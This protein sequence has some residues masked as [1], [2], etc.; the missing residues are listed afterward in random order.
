MQ[1]FVYWNR[2]NRM[3]HLGQQTL[4]GHNSLNIDATS[5]IYTSIVM[6]WSYLSYRHML[7]MKKFL[8][9]TFWFFS[10][11]SSKQCKLNTPKTQTNINIYALSR[12]TSHTDT[13]TGRQSFYYLQL[14]V[15]PLF[16]SFLSWIHTYTH[17]YGHLYYCLMN[18]YCYQKY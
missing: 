17:R 7:W 3:L 14:C 8:H 11:T 10:P 2:Y 9:C 1:N 16:C 6:I 5:M 13:L 15:S 12:I 18:S 4:R